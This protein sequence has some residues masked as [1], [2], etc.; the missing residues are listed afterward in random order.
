MAE[1]ITKPAKILVK[2]LA[3]D[4]I[5]ASLE[6]KEEQTHSLSKVQQTVFD[7]FIAHKHAT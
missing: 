5:K 4:T 2:E 7:L 3:M 6:E 1:K